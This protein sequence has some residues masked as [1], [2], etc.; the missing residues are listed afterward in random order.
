MNKMPIE[1]K[2]KN[3]V[4]VEPQ[5]PGYHVYSAFNVPRLGLPLMARI[6]RGQGYAVEVY[7]QQQ[8]PVPM[9]ALR[10][11]DMVGISTI[12]S[13]AD[14]AYKIASLAR[15]M[16]KP[17]VMGGPHVTFLPEEA[18][19]YCD[20]VVRGEGDETFPE[21]VR[22]MDVGEGLRA[23]R[24]LSYYDRGEYTE[25][26]ARPFISDMDS[27]PP[28]DLSSVHFGKKMSIVP[29]QTSRG[30]PY[31][32]T[33]CSVTGMFGHRYR[34]RHIENVLDEL[35]SY[36]D[37]RVF[38]VD[39]NFT[40]MPDRTMKLL[41][42]MRERGIRLKS[43]SAQTRVDIANHP[44][45]IALM[46]DTGCSRVYIGFES[47]NPLTLKRL[48]KQ[49]NVDDEK[50]AIEMLHRNRIR[51]HGM[52][53]L[54]T[55]DDAPGS[56]EKTLQF[57][58]S[59]SID[60]VQ[61]MSL[62]PL[63][64]TSVAH[65]IEKE[66]R[67]I[68]HQWSLYDGHHVVFRPRNMTAENLQQGILWS[69]KEFYSWRNAV[70]YAARF[71]I[72]NTFMRIL[73]SGIIRKAS[74]SLSNFG[75]WLHA[76]QEQ[77]ADWSEGFEFDQALSREHLREFKQRIADKVRE[78]YETVRLKISTRQEI[79]SRAVFLALEGHIDR[80][81]ASLIKR[82]IARY[83]HKSPTLVIDFEK[84]KDITPEGGDYLVRKLSRFTR[85][86]SIKLTGISGEFR[87][88]LARMPEN[89][90]NFELFD[91]MD[92]LRNKLMVKTRI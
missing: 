50:H 20:I 71:D 42:R 28:P 33:F 77:T 8:E 58:D 78:G 83:A 88:K 43:W 39:D 92:S 79:H 11:A 54:G 13:T 38:F 82:L 3:I 1:R 34:V 47:V 17:V 15:G 12:T 30:C 69:M 25:T 6:L 65:D 85:R 23:V 27:L 29:V 73:G 7:V 89:I 84:V 67:I 4:L 53:V 90:P 70:K 75:V 49:Q 18:L 60:T 61:F 80:R 45:L 19:Q 26:E 21:L 32:C 74:P 59:M 81:R 68:T 41:T 36:H 40:A 44:E 10:Q 72:V 57:T 91:S 2:I 16:G 37:R 64:G 66:G 22:T 5:A 51:V 24:G 48:N 86:V 14:E 55:D 87:E 35:E 9:S 62:I 52:F 46:R 63:P 76:H 56:V 31:H